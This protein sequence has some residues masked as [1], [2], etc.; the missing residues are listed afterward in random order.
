MKVLIAGS[1]HISGADRVR[2]DFISACRQIG[3][4]LA[5]ANAEF[6]VGTMSTNT[7][8]RYIVEGAASVEG[9]HK[10]WMYRPEHGET[11]ELPV[12]P[13]AKGTFEVHHRRLR[14]PWTASR[15]PQIQVADCVLLIGG[16]RGTTLVGYSAVALEKPV[17]AVGS[18]GGS[19]AELW[20]DLDPFYQRLVS[21][22]KH[23]G[24][25]R[26]QWSESNAE[27]AVEVLKEL[28]QRRIF[29]NARR[30]YYS[31][32]IL[33]LVLVLLA[34]WVWLFVAPPRPWQ[35]SFFVLLAI[36]AFLGTSLRGALA[37]VLDA[38]DR[39]R[40]ISVAE[41]N[42]GLILSFVLALLY[43]AGSFTFTGDF[44]AVVTR[45]AY[46]RVAVAMGL[47]GI[48]AGWLLERVAENLTRWFSR[49]LPG[50]DD[51]HS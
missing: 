1:L 22:K 17:L 48:A 15:V 13:D 2:D 19:A 45:D 20:R 37:A 6:V 42:A 39:P 3:A 50:A 18:F 14:G 7:A 47:I 16:R 36:S 26:E 25:L 43:L 9:T 4:A 34:A 49:R 11:P 21:T 46:Q 24:N 33:L 41:L 38:T 27:L 5:R 28:L 40:G 12:L 32:S 23:V 8:D 44:D 10:V 51:V 31:V 29:T 35:A 30:D